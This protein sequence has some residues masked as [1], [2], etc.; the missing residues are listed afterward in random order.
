[1]I[2]GRSQ[3]APAETIWDSPSALNEVSLRGH[4][5]DDVTNLETQVVEEFFTDLTKGMAK[6]DP[7]TTAEFVRRLDSYLT[8]NNFARGDS[9]ALNASST[10]ANTARFFLEE[11]GGIALGFDQLGRDRA[12][13]THVL[14]GHNSFDS[15]R[16][17]DYL[18][19]A[20]FPDARIIPIDLNASART[21]TSTSI[22]ADAMSLPFRDESVDTLHASALIHQLA[23][24]GDTH[25]RLTAITKEEKDSTYRPEAHVD[26]LLD[27]MNR[28][29][30]PGGSVLMH[31]QDL[32]PVTGVELD[33]SLPSAEL[34]P[35]VLEQLGSLSS[36]MS[37]VGL[38]L[39][40]SE[41]A[42]MDLLREWRFLVMAGNE[43]PANNDI[44][45]MLAP[46]AQLSWQMTAIATHFKKPS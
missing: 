19:R 25:S 34:M 26:R 24:V 10:Y 8:I 16:E 35:K 44:E 46:P 22:A 31:D 17:F 33:L 13:S 23:T 43:M 11:M 2:F 3:P 30:K 18:T 15:A 29:L 28:V 9:G 4:R 1:M 36:R 41:G 39:V 45:M 32:S 12:D 6:N 42:P 14:L 27:E 5:I 7:S 40:K 37:A 21:S 20:Y 38:E